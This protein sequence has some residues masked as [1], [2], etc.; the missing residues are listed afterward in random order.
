M[1]REKSKVHRAQSTAAQR[2]TVK[3]RMSEE[4]QRVK[5]SEVCHL[6]CGWASERSG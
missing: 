6:V 2:E 4:K 3:N 5:Q 1:V